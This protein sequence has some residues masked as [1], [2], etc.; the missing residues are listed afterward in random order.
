MNK[1]CSDLTEFYKILA[2]VG[3]ALLRV[4]EP[5]WEQYKYHDRKLGY[6]NKCRVICTDANIPTVSLTALWHEGEV[7]YGD[8]SIYWHLLLPRRKKELGKKEIQFEPGLKSE[9]IQDIIIESSHMENFMISP[10]ERLITAYL[11]L[12]EPNK[13]HV[14]RKIGVYT[15]DMESM[16]PSVRDKEIMRLINHQNLLSELWEE[17]NALV[18]FSNQSNPFN[19]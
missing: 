6:G 4:N 10:I 14:A 5:D 1:R 15:S 19:T 13:L 17:V 2:G 8:K 18:N 12:S 16:M 7:N 11:S 3:E 9:L